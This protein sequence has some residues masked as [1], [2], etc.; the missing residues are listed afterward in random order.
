M[1]VLGNMATLLLNSIRMSLTVNF[2][3]TDYGKFSVKYQTAANKLHHSNLI[4]KQ[5]KDTKYS[6]HNFNYNICGQL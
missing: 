6:L 5:F 3:C 4:I 2:S 1:A